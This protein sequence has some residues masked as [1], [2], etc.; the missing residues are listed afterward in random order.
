MKMSRF[1]TNVKIQYH[2]NKYRKSVE[3]VG[4]HMYRADESKG[5]ILLYHDLQILRWSLKSKKA[6]DRL[7]WINPD[8][9]YK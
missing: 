6:Q 4:H 8:I 1:L 2:I 5:T 7:F 3:K 9:R